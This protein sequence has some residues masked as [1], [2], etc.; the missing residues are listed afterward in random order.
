MPDPTRRSADA[1]GDAGAA[2]TDVA[3]R[4]L[5]ERCVRRFSLVDVGARWGFN[6]RWKRIS[7][8]A[9]VLCFEPDADEAGR[10][11][12]ACSPN[13]RYLPFGLAEVAAEQTLY[14]TVD[15]A[16]SSVHQP[17]AA[18][19]EHYPALVCTTPK[20]T[21]P[22]SCRSLDD[23]LAMER[24]ADVDIVKLDTQ[25]SELAILRGATRM[26]A[27]CVLVDIEVEFNPLYAG[28]GLFCHVDEFLRAHGFIL[29]RLE[30]LVHYPTETLAAVRADMTMTADPGGSIIA[31]VLNG[32]LFW[33]QAQ[34]VRAAYPRT[35]AESLP[36][37]QAIPAAVVAGIYGFWD[38]S[39]ELIRKTG[40]IELHRRVHTILESASGNGTGS[41]SG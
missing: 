6:D 12:A 20:R 17:I 26:L 14:V 7:D 28:Q 27:R 34:Y 23:V 40:D 21:I 29:W 16:C 8:S 2:A 10:L 22:I 11:N 33:G 18:L 13:V 24:I 9:D 5:L 38:L 35:G 3:L 1:S 4:I 36:P 15:P 30:N 25:G 39:L 32:Q 19:Y 37:E 31:P 41:R